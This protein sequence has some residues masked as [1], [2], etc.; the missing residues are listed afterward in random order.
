MHPRWKVPKAVIH[1]VIAVTEIQRSTSCSSTIYILILKF[2]YF[3]SYKQIPETETYLVLFDE[4]LTVPD[5]QSD[6]HKCY[7]KQSQAL[8]SLEVIRRVTVPQS[9]RWWSGP[10]H[11]I[12]QTLTLRFRAT[13]WN[14]KEMFFF[15]LEM[16]ET[17]LRNRN[18]GDDNGV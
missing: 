10:S 4:R 1:F 11:H 8:R 12:T 16:K 13:T 7:E 17:I 2:S 14:T 3:L 18:A 5:N 9:G 6:A 15:D